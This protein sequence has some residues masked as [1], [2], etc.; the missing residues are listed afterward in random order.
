[1]SECSLSVRDADYIIAL[2][3]C[4]GEANLNDIC[5]VL[6]IAKPTAS[7]MLKKLKDRGFI[8]KLGR[9]FVLTKAGHEI[10]LEISWRHAIT[11]WMLFKAG[12]PI[13]EACRVAR[14]IEL[15]IPKKA[16]FKIWISLGKPATCPCG[17][18]ISGIGGTC[19]PVND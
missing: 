16:L 13:K 10:A 18:K 17:Y 3:K 14:S 6:H 12:L 9:K 19:R 5:N 4:G 7:L 1:M 11:E 15:Y 8:Y 2:V